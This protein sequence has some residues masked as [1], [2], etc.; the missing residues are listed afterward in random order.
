MP[1]PQLP[2][3]LFYKVALWSLLWLIVIGGVG[4]IFALSD[5]SDDH[6]RADLANRGVRTL[7]IISSQDKL[8]NMHNVHRC[9]KGSY[10]VVAFTTKDENLRRTCVSEGL[11]PE[12]AMYLSISPIRDSR[13]GIIY[14]PKDASHFFVTSQDGT[15]PRRNLTGI[16]EVWIKRTAIMLAIYSLGTAFFL[17]RKNRL[18]AV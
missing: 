2:K 17:W 10:A 1:L 8:T 18:T 3:N 5:I 4:A 11:P 16:W 15:L 9:G 6:R 14:D 13:I 12:Y 7:G